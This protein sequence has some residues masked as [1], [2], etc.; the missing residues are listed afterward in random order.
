MESITIF[1]KEENDPL[2]YK[3]EKKGRKEGLEKGREA[4]IYRLLK[5]LGLSDEQTADIA[6]VPLQFVQKIRKKMHK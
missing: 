4:V 3:G 2:F 1:L 6:G 5:K